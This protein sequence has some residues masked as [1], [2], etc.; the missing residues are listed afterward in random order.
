MTGEDDDLLPIRPHIRDRV[1]ARRGRLHLYDRLDRARTA[2]VVIDMQELFCAE[3]AAAEVPASRALAAPINS[4]TAGLRARGVPVLWI[5]HANTRLGDGS[6]WEMF[7]GQF[8]SGAVRER[9]VEAL[10]P[11]RQAVWSGLTQGNADLTIVK[12]RYSALISGASSLERVLRSR[13]IDTLLIAG[14]KTD[15]C[16][17]STAR[18]AMMLDFRV[19]MVAD[20][21]AALSEE[22]HRDAL[23]TVIQQFGDVMTGAEVLRRLDAEA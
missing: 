22:E 19:V 16:C 21:C 2:L 11:G 15:V 20:C 5:V 23:E 10:A 6:D 17:E 8:V 1:L 18:D 3:G 12:N 13:G 4:L 9:T 14:T 7:F